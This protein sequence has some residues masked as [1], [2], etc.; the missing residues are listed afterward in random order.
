[1]TV[2]YVTYYLH[3][4]LLS[5]Y[6]Y[7]LLLTHCSFG[8]ASSGVGIGRR[9]SHTIRKTFGNGISFGSILFF[10]VGS[11]LTF[12]NHYHFVPNPLPFRTN[13]QIPKRT[14]T[15]YHFLIILNRTLPFYSY[16]FDL[17]QIHIQLCTNLSY[18]FVHKYILTPSRLIYFFV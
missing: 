17:N 1:M 14:K 10:S 7:S 12:L 11:L 9:L 5:I 18:F 2:C 3:M 13:S 15:K 6:A 4:N 16:H 8:Q